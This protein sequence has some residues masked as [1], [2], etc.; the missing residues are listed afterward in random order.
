MTRAVK[1]IITGK[2]VRE[3]ANS[4]LHVSVGFS[5]NITTMISGRE[6]Q[7]PDLIQSPHV[8]LKKCTLG[9]AT[10]RQYRTWCILALSGRSIGF[11]LW[12]GPSYY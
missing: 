8:R 11:W 12:R 9:R 2:G 7:P 5:Q 4:H 3:V 10:I 6:H 1:D